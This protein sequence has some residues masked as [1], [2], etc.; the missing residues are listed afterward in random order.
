[1]ERIDREKG[2]YVFVTGSCIRELYRDELH[3]Q[4]E[5]SNG[6]IL[7][8]LMSTV[9]EELLSGVVYA[10]SAFAVWADLKEQLDKV[11]RMRI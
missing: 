1:M 9:S 4:W 5:T 7:S 6:I 2:K 11:N 8:W 10:T 3:K